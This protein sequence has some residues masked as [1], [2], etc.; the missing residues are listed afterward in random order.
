[1]T[2]NVDTLLSQWELY[3]LILVRITAFIYTAPF[4]SMN[5]VPARTQLG[6]AFFFSYII[7]CITPMMELLAMQF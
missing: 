7:L 6:L 4:L 3:L 2:L 1:M 5:N